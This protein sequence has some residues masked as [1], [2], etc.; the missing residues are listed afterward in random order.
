M[1]KYGSGQIIS[2]DGAPIRRTASAPL[3]PE[4]VAD[5]EHEDGPTVLQDDPEE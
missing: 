5:I 1:R 4:D 2:D 3:S